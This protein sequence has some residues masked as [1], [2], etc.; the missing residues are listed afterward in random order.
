ML[1]ILVARNVYHL[2]VLFY[3]F[4]IAIASNQL[5]VMSIVLKSVTKVLII[6]GGQKCLPKKVKFMLAISVTYIPS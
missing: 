1:I 5:L 2:N 6:I 3:A 4:Y